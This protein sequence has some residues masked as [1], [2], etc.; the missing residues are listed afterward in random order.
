MMEDPKRSAPFKVALAAEASSAVLYL[1]SDRWGA[2]KGGLRVKN[3]SLI[4]FLWF[5][6]W[7][8]IMHV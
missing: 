2:L 6:A 8:L 4:G 5:V 7:F 3:R 1:S